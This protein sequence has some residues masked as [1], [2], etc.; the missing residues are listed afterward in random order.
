M[1]RSGHSFTDVK[2]SR[3]PD[4]CLFQSRYYLDCCLSALILEFIRTLRLGRQKVK[5]NKG[6]PMS[7]VMPVLILSISRFRN[8]QPTRKEID[9][10]LPT[11]SDPNV[12]EKQPNNPSSDLE[13]YIK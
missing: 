8:G 4:S 7:Q 2:R 11:D 6:R 9:Q 5:A 13:Q 1:A 3:W 10:Y 12:E